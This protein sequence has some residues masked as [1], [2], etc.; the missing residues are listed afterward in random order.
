MSWTANIDVVGTDV[1]GAYVGV[2]FTSDSGKTVQDTLR[3][4]IATPNDVKTEIANR[5]EQ[6]TSQDAIVAGI[7]KGVFVPPI[8]QI[9]DVPIVVPPTDAEIQQ[10]AY[11]KALG[12]RQMVIE[13]VN[14]GALD[15]ADPLVAGSIDAVQSAF[16]LVSPGIADAINDAKT[17]VKAAP[18]AAPVSLQDIAVP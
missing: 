14:A 6:L 13:A 3:F 17:T 18:I 7:S 16:A 11:Q 2:T 1:Q 12:V 4:K 5:L 10:A 8:P 15:G 9:P